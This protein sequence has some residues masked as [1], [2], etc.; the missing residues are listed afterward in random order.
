MDGTDYLES[1]QK[2]IT[3]NLY[4]SALAYFNIA[5]QGFHQARQQKTPFQAVI[6]NFSISVELFLKGYIAR[7]AFRFLYAE[8]PLH[9]QVMLSYPKYANRL[10]LTQLSIDLKTFNLKTIDLSQSITLFY[11]ID[12]ATQPIFHSYFKYLNA[13][14]NPC[15]HGSLPTFHRFDL[16]RVT[17]SSLRLFQYLDGKKEFQSSIYSLSDEDELFLK[18]YDDQRVERVKEA[19]DVAKRNVKKLKYAAS[20]VGTAEDWD[21]LVVQCPVCKSEGEAGGYCD[22]VLVPAYDEGEM[23]IGLNFYAGS[24]KCSNCELELADEDEL[25]LAGIATKYERNEDLSGWLNDNWV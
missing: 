7:H 24:F 18:R 20:S 10:F 3:E 1:L 5:R 14:R 22:P 23:P 12:P 25:E 4:N 16:E 2:E 17:F 13:V 9:L 21:T 19:I 15:V 8:M 6:G 11:I